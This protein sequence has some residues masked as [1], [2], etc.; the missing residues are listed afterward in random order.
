MAAS[1]LLSLLACTQPGQVAGVASDD[2][3]ALIP[4][5]QSPLY[6][7]H[8]L[9]GAIWR[10][11]DKRFVTAEEL[12]GSL[13]ASS[14]L[15]LGEKHDNPDH[16]QLQLNLLRHLL[17]N[18]L[19]TSV[20][21]EMMDSSFA[22][23]LAGVEQSGFGS[24][25]Q[26]KEVLQWDEAGW[27]WDFY[28]PLVAEALKAGVAVQTANLSGERVGQV[29]GEPLDPQIAGV[30]DA[31]AL[32]QMNSEIDESHC[33]M[34]PPSQFPAMVRVQQARDHAMAS[35]LAA[36][37]P[38]GRVNILL[39]GNYHVRRDLGVPRYLLALD[40]EIEPDS[41]LS[42]ALLEVDPDSSDPMDYLQAYS[43]VLPFDYV[44]F[45]PALTDEDYCAGF[46]SQ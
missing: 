46:R 1:A 3:V 28:G 34:L 21:F 6:Q 10:A 32:E 22:D 38:G 27:D 9:V 8:P 41:I 36:I 19:V 43:D 40:P 25:Q 24:L 26:L 44:W 20:S 45:T 31:P 17:G 35:S 14:Y 12:T 42:V 23:R 7:D 5:W 29:Y 33:N 2:S 30:L 16:H 15:L 18:D 4:A 39:A 11:G 13:S 37:A